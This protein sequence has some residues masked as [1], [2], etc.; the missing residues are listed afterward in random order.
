MQQTVHQSNEEL[1]GL[2]EELIRLPLWS[3][4]V[5]PNSERRSFHYGCRGVGIILIL[6]IIIFIHSLSYI[7]MYVYH[8][9]NHDVQ[10]YHTYVGVS[11]YLCLSSILNYFF[12]M[13]VIFNVHQCCISMHSV[14]V[15]NIF[16]Y[17]ILYMLLIKHKISLMFQFIIDW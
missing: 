14:Y 15:C 5:C 7:Y 10:Y 11:V 12:V 2:V 4:V 1:D 8:Y 9:L 17:L 16:Y 6:K 3:L 13:H